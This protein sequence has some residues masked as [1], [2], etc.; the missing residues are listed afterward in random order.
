VNYTFE[1]GKIYGLI[2]RNGSGKTMLLRAIAGLIYPSEGTVVID[3]KELHKDINFPESVGLIIEK[4]ELLPEYSGFVNLKMLSKIN[5]IATEA[6]IRNVLENVGL[7]SV[8]KKKVRAYSLGMKQKLSIAQALLEDP[9]LLL[10]DEPTNA[11]DKESVDLVRNIFLQ[12]K[13]ENKLVIIASHIREDIEL[14]SDTVVEMQAGEI[15]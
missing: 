10:L 12:K 3:G 7:D 4:T 13:A 11:L 1:S 9:E 6:D 2:G 14:L 5:R 15:L 8:L